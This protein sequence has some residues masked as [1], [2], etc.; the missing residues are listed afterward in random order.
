R[1]STL[2]VVWIG[3]DDSDAIADLLVEDYQG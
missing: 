1:F 3:G 2:S